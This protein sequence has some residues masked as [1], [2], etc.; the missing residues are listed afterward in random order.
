LQS[1]RVK[2]I[3]RPRVDIMAVPKEMSVASVLSTVRE[4]GYSL[5]P[6]YDG[7]IDNIVGIVLAKTVLDFFVKGVLVDE[8]SETSSTK[9]E[10]NERE[11][12]DAVASYSLKS[13]NGKS[14]TGYVRA[15]TGAQMASRMET[16]IED[17]NLIDECYFVPDTANGWSVLQE[18]R[19]R[20][21]HMAIVVDEY[22]GT[23]GLVSLEDIVEEV[24][25][26]IYD[27]DDEGDFEFSEESITMQED[28]SFLVRGDADLED[29]DVILDLNLDEEV[30]LKEFGTLSGFLFMCAGEI[31]KIG[32]FVV[33]RGWNFEI[34]DADPKR[35]RTVKVEKLLGFFDDNNVDKDHA[36][37]KFLNKKKE[38][39]SDNESDDSDY[40]DDGHGI[41][42]EASGSAEMIANKVLASNLD[43]A[44]RIDRMVEDGGRK[45]TY[46][47]ELMA[48]ERNQ[49]NE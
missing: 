42:G 37:L 31:P 49:S 18:M 35:I 34:I 15:F 6:V 40:Y 25:G 23:E 39:N 4:I 24:V 46:V 10:I 17:A 19:K 48:A 21:I 11:E 28:G 1:Q 16:T 14:Q 2:E 47:K 29:C 22:G 12:D 30:T 3:M 8:S 38:H 41:N 33:T 43:V 9:K 36:V 20:R 27:E 45:K 5:I 7:E 13:L 44:E 32:D 26:E